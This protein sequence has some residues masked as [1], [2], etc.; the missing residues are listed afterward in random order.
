MGTSSAAQLLG[1]I[2]QQQGSKPERSGGSQQQGSKPERS[3]GSCSKSVLSVQTMGNS[4]AAQ[5][6]GG[7]AQQQ[8]SKPR[9]SSNKKA[10]ESK[11]VI[12]AEGSTNRRSGQRAG[13]SVLSVKHTS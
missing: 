12:G 4:S 9:S 1:G 5:L 6:L 11:S 2:S 10:F 8:G 7:L 13:G 3:G